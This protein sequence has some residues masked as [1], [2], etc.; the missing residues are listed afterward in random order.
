MSLSLH[1]SLH[2]R[3]IFPV[4]VHIDLRRSMPGDGSFG[5]F[6]DD[7]GHRDTELLHSNYTIALFLAKN[8]N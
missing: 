8:I 5:F 7:R 2:Y 6:W 3:T 4:S 1:L